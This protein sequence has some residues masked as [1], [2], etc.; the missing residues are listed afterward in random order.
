MLALCRWK[1]NAA[2]TV[3]FLCSAGR[4]D[5]RRGRSG[6]R[7]HA[8]QR[9]RV[10]VFCRGR[11][12]SRHA[13]LSDL[14]SLRFAAAVSLRRRLSPATRN[15]SSSL[16]TTGLHRLVRVVGIIFP[17]FKDAWL[18]EILLFFFGVP[19]RIPEL[20]GSSGGRVFPLRSSLWRTYPSPG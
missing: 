16:L 5:R 1:P 2:V 15:V 20:W 12:G 8:D 11:L 4:G 10:S 7:A 9:R 3:C 6:R 14:S 13:D 19:E 18:T 17:V